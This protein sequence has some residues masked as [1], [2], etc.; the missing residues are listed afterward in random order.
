MQAQGLYDSNIVLSLKN[1][2]YIYMQ[3]NKVGEAEACYRQALWIGEQLLGPERSL[4]SSIQ[5]D[6]GMLYLQRENF[7]EAEPCFQKAAATWE[8][9]QGTD[10][11]YTVDWPKPISIMINLH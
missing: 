10:H 1:R 2:D 4:I 7:A 9:T 5:V 3:Q 8:K 6:L 11:I